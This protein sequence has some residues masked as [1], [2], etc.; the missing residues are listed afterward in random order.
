MHNLRLMIFVLYFI[1]NVIGQKVSPSWSK[2]L[3]FQILEAVKMLFVFFFKIDSLN[4]HH[5]LLKNSQKEFSNRSLV[6]I[7]SKIYFSILLQHLFKINNQIFCNIKI[8]N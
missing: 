3:K 6:Q 5:N 4:L 2:N 1:K 8:Q 7:K